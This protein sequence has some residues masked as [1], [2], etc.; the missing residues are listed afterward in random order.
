VFVFD[1]VKLQRGG[2]LFQAMEYLTLQVDFPRKTC[3]ILRK[4]VGNMF[5]FR[6]MK[7]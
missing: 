6:Q 7:I 3:V 5:I 2:G 4:T 1:D